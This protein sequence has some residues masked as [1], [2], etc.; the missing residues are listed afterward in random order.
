M[1]A[2]T[3]AILV[4]SGSGAEPVT[5]ISSCFAAPGEASYFAG[6]GQRSRLLFGAEANG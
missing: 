4:G 3:P 2:L 6:P 5:V 1:T